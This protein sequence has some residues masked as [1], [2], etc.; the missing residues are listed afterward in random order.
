MDSRETK[1]R[2]IA[3]QHGWELAG[4][5]TI[6]WPRTRSKLDLLREAWELI[7]PEARAGTLTEREL[8]RCNYGHL[9]PGCRPFA[10]WLWTRS[11]LRA[12]ANADAEDRIAGLRAEGE[13]TDHEIDALDTVAV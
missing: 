8:Q 11:D 9:R 2:S 1:L 6:L 4:W 7:E 5:T 13:L 12:L 10:Y 3:A